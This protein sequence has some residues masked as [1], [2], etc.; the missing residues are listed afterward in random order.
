MVRA[1]RPEGSECSACGGRAGDREGEDDEP[2]SAERL[3]GGERGPGSAGRLARG[4]GEP[5]APPPGRGRQQLVA[6]TVTLGGSIVLVAALGGSSL[7]AMVGQLFVIGLLT[8]QIFRGAPWAR[9]VVVALAL[10]VGAGNA[11]NAARL[12]GVDGS[13]WPINAGLAAVYAWCAF[14][15]AFSRPLA[16]FVRQQ[17]AKLR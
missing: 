15:L 7:A 12:F 6:V 11:V 1:V 4:G 13:S 8:L 3:R 16:S 17:R 5:E 9:W 14:I 10:L 2:L